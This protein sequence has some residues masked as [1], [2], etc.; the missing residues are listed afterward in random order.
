MKVIVCDA[1]PL[2]FLAKLDRLNLIPDVLQGRV[3]V[4]RCVVDEVSSENAGVTE[5]K[6]VVAFLDSVEIIDFQAPEWSSKA[7]SQSDQSTLSWAIEHRADWL[8]A[9]ERLLR[10]VAR[11]ESRST[12]GFLGILVEAAR[13]GIL[14]P[15]EAREAID[16]SISRHGC[17][18]AVDLYQRTL[19][20]LDGL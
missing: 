8:V 6:R 20:E 11:E 13:Q 17:R 16:E 2:I 7:L 12:I 18:I 19:S 3:S 14:S 15:T 5:T 4:L 1:S 9:D 10:R